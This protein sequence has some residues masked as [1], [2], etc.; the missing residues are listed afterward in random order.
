MLILEGLTAGYD[1]VPIL[2]DVDM[3]VEEGEIVAIAGRNGVGKS[4]LAKAI[5]GLI[6]TTAG[7]KRFAGQ[8][9][10]R[11]DPRRMALAGLGYVP[12]GREIFTRLTVQE[13]LMMGDM[14]GGSQEAPGYEAVYAWFPILEKRRTQKAGTLSGGEQQMLAIGRAL[15]GGAKLL[16]LDEPS[17][18]I[19]PTIVAE[20]AQV[21]RQEN[22]KNRLTI[23]LIEQNVGLILDTAHRCL[24][25]E[26]G[27]ITKE[28]RPSA[29]A[30]P[31]TAA[32]LLA[33]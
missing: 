14:V 12:Q 17:D 25:M 11:F 29:L 28:M 23:L 24:V 6:R 22:Q 31:E 18:G 9:A 3:T 7:T 10:T 8:E 20:I 33:I 21:L 5:A 32:R 30:D 19:Q 2:R 13:N 27:S 26:K 4:T 16:L 1:D 15:V